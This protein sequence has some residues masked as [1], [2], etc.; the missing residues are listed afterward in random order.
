MSHFHLREPRVPA[1]YPALAAVRSAAEPDWP[2]TAVDLERFDQNHDPSHYHTAVVAEQ[3]GQ[4]VGVGNIGHD[5]FSFETWRYWGGLRVH[6]D[7]QRQ[8][9]GSALY[10]DLL[11]R[12]QARGARELRTMSSDKPHAAAGRAFL[13]KRGWQVAWERYESEL[14]TENIDL[15][16]FDA[17]LNRVTG[18]GIQLRSLQELAH[19]PQRNGWLHELDWLL[20]EDVPIG[21]TITKRSLEV[22]VKDE[23]EDPSLRPQMSFVALDP[24]RNDPLTGPYVGY[25]T[26]GYNEGGDYSFIGMTGVR[27]EYRGQGIA[28]ALKVAAMRALHEAGGGLI[29]TFNDPPNKA[30]LGMNAQLGFQ[31][32]A[33]IYRY[34]LKLD[35]AQ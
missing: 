7:A 18:A 9:I 32:T 4:V 35:G 29:R 25:S 13:A 2:V 8:G 3:G 27:R 22:W 33:T 6:P 20:F 19:I 34:E 5:D 24:T 1:D 15:H 14:H 23:L 17:L 31:R 28:K 12:V 16:A 10:D 30:M 11:R 26:L 21:M